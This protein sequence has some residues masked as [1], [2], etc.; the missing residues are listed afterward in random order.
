M[1]VVVVAVAVAATAA[2]V[3]IVLMA[4]ETVRVC[5]VCEICRCGTGRNHWHSRPV[6]WTWSGSI[7]THLFYV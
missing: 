5:A 2:V 1:G 6:Q 7:W 4:I 3:F